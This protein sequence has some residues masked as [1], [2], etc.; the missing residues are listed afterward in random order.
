MKDT[1]LKIVEAARALGA[2]YADV[3]QITTEIETLAVKN[4]QVIGIVK[5]VSEGYGVRVLKKG[6]WGFSC[7][8][9]LPL[10]ERVVREAVAIADCSALAPRD[11]GVKFPAAKAIVAEYKTPFAVDPFTVSIEKKLE[12]LMKADRAMREVPEIK[13]ALSSLG[14][15]RETRL[16]AS[17]E[18]S[19]IR[20]ELLESGGGIECTAVGS[21]EV[22]KRSYPNSFGRNQLTSGF[23]MVEA[24]DLPG[25]ARRIA[26]EAAALL[27]APACP[28]GTKTIILD[29]TQLA[30][31]I[32]ESCGHAVE[33]DRVYGMEASFA[34][35]SF[36]T[37]EKLNTFQYGSDI[38][39]LYQDGTVKTGL[40]TYGYDDDGVPTCRTDLVKNGR[41]VGYLSNRETAAD[42]GV[43]SCGANRA[44]SWRFTPIVRMTNINLAPGTWDFDAL[45][46][47]T[48]EGLYL[49]TNKSWSIDDKRM[50]FQFGTE[51][52]YEIKDGKLG[53]LLKNPIYTGMTPEFWKNCDAICN[54]KH[55]QILGTPNCGKGQP[56]QTAHV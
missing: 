47:D 6:A 19:F 18:G 24:M 29:A 53:R 3:R 27:T 52:A 16:F 30:L 34:G 23:E 20:Q 44:T 55:W 36:L 2:D 11:G 7:S 32:H 43:P 8:P 31:Q 35:S 5:N 22:Q 48:R 10:W 28:S 15:Q 14:F 46:S 1:L 40:G 9:D 13:V 39:N 45:I 50:N 38:V 42:L 51:L 25:N 4:G 41:F 26:D 49:I 33:L 17:T 37:T 12:L 21:G 56:M 54:E